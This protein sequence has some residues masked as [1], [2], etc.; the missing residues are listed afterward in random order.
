MYKQ[1]IVMRSDLNMPKGKIMAQAAHASMA[2]LLKVMRGKEYYE[3]DEE[4]LEKDELILNLKDNTDIK[5]WLKG[6]FVKI[7]LKVKSEDEL[8]DIYEKV[9][10]KNIIHSLIIDDGRTMFNGVKTKTCIAIGPA[11]A[12]IIDEI[13]GGLKLF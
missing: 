12:T 8:V 3:C 5:E 2:V 9:K 6:S 11:E 13:T 4:C 1:V 10:D 7:G